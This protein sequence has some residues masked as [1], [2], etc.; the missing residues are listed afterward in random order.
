ML[1]R[2]AGAIAGAAALAILLAMALRS[3]ETLQPEEEPQ[4]ELKGPWKAVRPIMRIYHLQTVLGAHDCLT[5]L[6]I[7]SG[8]YK[9]GLD[10]AGDRGW[11]VGEDVELDHESTELAE[12]QARAVTACIR[13]QHLPAR[14]RVPESLREFLAEGLT[15][16]MEIEF[17]LRPRQHFE[18]LV[19]SGGS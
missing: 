1:G 11:L 6:G 14:L 12:S 10:F 18:D 16:Y 8:Y 9:A 15:S 5:S 19:R 7:A 2:I 4:E 17:P 3:S 13:K